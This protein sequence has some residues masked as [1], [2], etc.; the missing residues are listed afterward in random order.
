MSKSTRIHWLLAILGSTLLLT[1]LTGGA[2]VAWRK[3]AVERQQR[4][5]NE[6]PKQKEIV[7]P[8]MD[9]IKWMVEFTFDWALVIGEA[10]GSTEV[11][12]ERITWQ[13]LSEIA[14][15]QEAERQI[16]LLQDHWGRVVQPMVLNDEMLAVIS[17]GAN[18][19]FEEGEG[20][21]IWIGVTEEMFKKG[22]VRIKEQVRQKGEALN[23][24]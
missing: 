8:V 17:S 3:G 11:S 24:K 6:L 19:K 14:K 20:D 4:Q 12:K 21:D 1:W 13:Y 23:P 18:G 2:Y 16:K 5:R 10:R 9:E 22:M 15:Q 7:N